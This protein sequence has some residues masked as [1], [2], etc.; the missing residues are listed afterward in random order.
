MPI[1][2]RAEHDG[3]GIALSEIESMANAESIRC[4]FAEQ[5][6]DAMVTEP[7]GPRDYRVYIVGMPIGL[8]TEL[9][10]RANIEL[11]V[12]ARR[13]QFSQELQ[14]RLGGLWW[15]ISC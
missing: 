9:V 10:T 1:R 12:I 6:I 13:F 2:C 15:P 8:F 14:L 3:V 11:I 7:K 5:G 4:F